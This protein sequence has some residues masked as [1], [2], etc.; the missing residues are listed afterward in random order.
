MPALRNVELRL[1]AELMKNSRRSDRELAKAI[2]VSQPTVSRIIK[3]LEKEGYIQEHATIPD[4][5]KLGYEIMALTFI[6]LAKAA[7]SE[8]IKKARRI[9]TEALRKGPFE[10]AMLERGT[11]LGY[12]GV[13]ISYHKDYSSYV[14]LIDWFKQFTFLEIATLE[15]FLINLEDEIHYRPLTF[16]TISQHLLMQGTD[17]KK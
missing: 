9:A 7:T 14:K 17:E 8:D 12:D 6:K 15:S 16:A 1:I 3:S 4:F 11:G 5:R 2:G 10:I 13:A